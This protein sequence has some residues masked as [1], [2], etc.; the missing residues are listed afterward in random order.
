MARAELFTSRPLARFLLSIAILA[1]LTLAIVRPAA[2]SG[3]YT[4]TLDQ[5]CI[6]CH[7]SGTSPDLNPR[8]Q[9]FA[10][11][12]TH[13]TD[14]TTA[15]ASAVQTV[16]LPPADEGGFPGEV[17]PIAVL[18]LLLGWAVSM[19]RRRRRALR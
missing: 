12:E 5:P 2:S 4:Q 17:I 15:W 13:Q 18:L 8:G 7:V 3:G 6:S 11:V 14:P 19:V 10:A 9:V 1:C 16:P